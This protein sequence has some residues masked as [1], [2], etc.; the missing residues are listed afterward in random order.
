MG[1]ILAT[2]ERGKALTANTQPPR[3]NCCSC[4]SGRFIACVQS[5]DQL[6]MRMMLLGRIHGTGL[7]LMFF[8]NLSHC[9]SARGCYRWMS[10]LTSTTHSLLLR[11]LRLL[12]LPPPPP[13]AASAVLPRSLPPPAA[14]IDISCSL[15]EKV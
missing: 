14:V 9:G 8:R 5:C 4:H 3:S 2:A 10:L 15:R 12:L 6:A 11:R 13:L 1:G 7:A